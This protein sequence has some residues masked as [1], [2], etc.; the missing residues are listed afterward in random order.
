MYV[1]GGFGNVS[2]EPGFTG[3]FF[4]FIDMPLWVNVLLVFVWMQCSI[5][6]GCAYLFLFVGD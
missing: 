4:Q 2:M 3:I 6:V 1:S 5:A